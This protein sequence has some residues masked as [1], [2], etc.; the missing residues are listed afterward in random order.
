MYI[1]ILEWPVY[2]LKNQNI[3]SD[4]I[5]SHKKSCLRLLMTWM[6]W[7]KMKQVKGEHVKTNRNNDTTFLTCACTFTWNPIIFLVNQPYDQCMISFVCCCILQ[8]YECLQLEMNRFSN[9]NP[10]SFFSKGLF[11]QDAFFVLFK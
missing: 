4:V 7:L 11:F 1:S 10:P 6:T 2:M 9:K 3:Y 8:N 5:I